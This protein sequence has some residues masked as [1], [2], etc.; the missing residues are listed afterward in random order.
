LR[1]FEGHRD[2]VRSLALSPDGRFL[3]TGADDREIRWWDFWSGQLLAVLKGHT[4]PVT[5]LAFTREGGLVSGSWNNTVK[6]WDLSR[7]RQVWSVEVP[8]SPMATPS[9]GD[10]EILIACWDGKVRGL[11]RRNGRVVRTLSAHEH[12]VLSL[13]TNGDGSRLVTGGSDKAI[14][15]WTR[16]GRLLSTLRGHTDGVGDL[17]FAADGRTLASAGDDTIRIWDLPTERETR[18]FHFLRLAKPEEAQ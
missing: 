12:W 1:R 10:E 13:A 7:K 14:H 15:L 3:A 18:R 4:S 11:D 16:D 9:V 6:L 5:G 8:N 17:A 2:A